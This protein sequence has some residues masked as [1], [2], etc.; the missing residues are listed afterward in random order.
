MCTSCGVGP[1]SKTKY[2]PRRSHF[3]F[4]QKWKFKYDGY[5]VNSFTEALKIVS[6]QEESVLCEKICRT[7]FDSFYAYI[8]LIRQYIQICFGECLQNCEKRLLDSSYHFVC[9]PETTRH[10]WKDFY[11]VWYLRIYRK[12]VKQI[13]DSLKEDENN[14]YYTRRP[15][16]IRITYFSILNRMGNVSGKTC[17]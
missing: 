9:P 6:K 7:T 5:R 16:Y 12:S 1:S 14:G 8:G 15:I 10:H 13:Q 17:R 3:G 11:N 2:I 4:R